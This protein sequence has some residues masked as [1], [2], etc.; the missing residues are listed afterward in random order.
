MGILRE[1]CLSRRTNARNRGIRAKW[2]LVGDEETPGP[3]GDQPS[4]EQQEISTPNEGDEVQHHPFTDPTGF[5][6]DDHNR[7][8]N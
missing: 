8:Y 2:G 6:D 4:P 3:I 7:G 1:D 5:Y